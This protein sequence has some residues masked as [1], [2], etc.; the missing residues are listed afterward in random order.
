[1][2]LSHRLS[3]LNFTSF[4]YNHSHLGIV[5]T[6]F[7]YALDLAA[8]FNSSNHFIIEEIKEL[9]H[10]IKAQRFL[11]LFKVSHK[12]QSYSRLQRKLLLRHIILLSQHLDRSRKI[13]HK[14]SMFKIQDFT[15]KAA[16]RNKSNKFDSSLGLHFIYTF[17]GA[18]LI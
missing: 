6:S 5:K 8:Y 10:L 14:H 13:V 9:I 16:P 17:S 18:K 3:G 15:M 11:S 12:A 2:G 1:M 7:A 4:I